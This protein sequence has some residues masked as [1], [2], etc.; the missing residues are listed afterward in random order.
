M[1]MQPL[2]VFSDEVTEGRQS[3]RAE[4]VGPCTTGGDRRAG[5]IE[6]L[7]CKR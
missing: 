2:A 3:V 5:R 6:V 1:V 7:C 4:V